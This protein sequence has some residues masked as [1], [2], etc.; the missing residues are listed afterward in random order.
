MEF[1][2]VAILFHSPVGVFGD[3]FDILAAI[4]YSPVM[5]RLTCSQSQCKNVCFFKWLRSVKGCTYLLFSPETSPAYTRH[6]L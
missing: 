5:I 2:F 1:E 3:T 4:F 6:K